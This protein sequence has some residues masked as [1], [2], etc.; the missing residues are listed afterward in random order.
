[1]IIIF[2]FFPDLHSWL[3]LFG[4]D[5]YK[6][7]GS[8]YHDETI[9]QP[10]PGLVSPILGPGLRVI[11]GL[12]CSTEGI[13]KEFSRPS[14]VH[15]SNVRVDELEW[16]NP[17]LTKLG[18]FSSSGPVLGPGVLVSRVEEKALVTLVPTRE[19]S[20]VQAVARDLLNGSLLLDITLPHH[21]HHTLYLVKDTSMRDEDIQQLERLSG[22]FNVTVHQAEHPEVRVTGSSAS[23]VLMY[24]VSASSARHRLLRHVLRKTA[25]HAWE[26][27]RHLVARGGPSLKSWT[28]EEKEIL[29]REGTVPGYTPA[30]L[31]SVHR[32]PLLADDASNVVFR[33]DADRRR[34]RSRTKY[35]QL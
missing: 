14:M 4:V 25:D 15:Q 16:S 20:V 10:K 7:L 23:L 32:F 35:P 5:L 13:L 1:M 2:T 9:D 28:P 21:R 26:K 3:R 6:M 17:E 29:L 33:R 34:R 18:A 24:G 19:N 8:N 31:H 27:E 30:E 11:S 12:S 22:L